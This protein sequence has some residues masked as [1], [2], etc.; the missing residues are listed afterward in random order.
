M[1]PSCTA[2]IEFA[3]STSLRAAFSGLAK[4]RSAVSFISPRPSWPA[5]RAAGYPRHA[6][7]RPCREPVLD[8]GKPDIIGPAIGA[9]LDRVAAFIVGAIN[10]HAA[11]ATGAHLS[12]RDFLL[13]GKFGHSPRSRSPHVNANYNSWG[14][15]SSE[16]KRWRAAWKHFAAAYQML[17]VTK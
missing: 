16:L 17:T 14:V 1:R 15:G 2:S 3:I 6:F 4:G 11:H 7:R 8:V 13:A 9:H 10:Q 5:G 12:K